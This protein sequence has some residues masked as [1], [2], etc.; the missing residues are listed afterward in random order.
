MFNR[1]HDGQRIRKIFRKIF[2]EYF[3][4]LKDNNKTLGLANKP[5]R[6]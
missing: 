2:K 1:V 5:H 4:F 3:A 6:I